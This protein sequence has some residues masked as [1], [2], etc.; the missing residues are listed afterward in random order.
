MKKWGK[1]ILTVTGTFGEQQNFFKTLKFEVDMNFLPLQIHGQLSSNYA[2]KNITKGM[3]SS[4]FSAINSVIF[5]LFWLNSGLKIDEYLLST[6]R[7]LQNT[8]L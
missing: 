4:F 3:C 5:T 2:S 7:L 8:R 1:I 6:E